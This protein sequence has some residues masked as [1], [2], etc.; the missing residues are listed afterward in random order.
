MHTITM[1]YSGQLLV[2]HLA[3][4]GLAAVLDVNGYDVS[5]AHDR[6]SL[7]FE[8]LVRFDA[9]PAAV[10]E[11]VRSS[12]RAAEPVVEADIEPGL[13]GIS[14]R[15][16]IW[17]RATFQKDRSRSSKVLA[18]RNELV[19]SADERDERIVQ[20]LLAGLGAS[21]AWGYGDV[22]PEHGATALDGVLG[23][24]TSDFVR[25][26]LRRSRGAAASLEPSETMDRWMGSVAPTGADKTGWAPSG[27]I[28]HP[29]DQW[30]AALGLSLLPVAHHHEQ[31][32]ATPGCWRRTRPS[33]RGVTLPIVSRPVSRSRLRALLA[34]D[35][36]AQAGLDDAAAAA[37]LKRFGIEE[38]VIFQRVYAAGAG[39]S[40]AF[41]FDRGRR[42]DL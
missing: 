1:P 33:R 15:P 30:L 42:V 38:V 16:V 17:A 41:T 28:V 25:G 8:P 37:R 32:S 35:V 3:A 10:V 40:V 22:K 36:L 6:D 4:Y 31:A 26:V 27:T 20:G 12:A 21:A 18:L 11:A 39:S 34:L 13:S 29:V 24:N 7:S 19:A 23:N 5:V 2:A 9:D 14:R